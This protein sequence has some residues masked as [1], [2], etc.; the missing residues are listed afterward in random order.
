MLKITDFNEPEEHPFG[1]LRGY[2]HPIEK[3]RVLAWMLC[4]CINASNLDLE[5]R[6]QHNHSTMVNDELLERVDILR[7]KLTTKSIGLLFAWYGKG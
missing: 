5:I 4:Q 7:Y 1:M 6:T 2:T 3:E